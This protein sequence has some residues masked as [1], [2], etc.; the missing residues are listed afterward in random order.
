MTSLKLTD[1]MIQNQAHTAR[2]LQRL[3]SLAF[4]IKFFLLL[5]MFYGYQRYVP[6]HG[7]LI[8]TLMVEA[9]CLILLN[10]G[11]HQT[12]FRVLVSAILI[13]CLGTG[14]VF[15]AF[16]VY[17]MGGV[18]MA[19]I[20]AGMLLG[21][22]PLIITA[23]SGFGIWALFMTLNLSGIVPVTH[24]M[25]T[26]AELWVSQTGFV[27]LLLL[28]LCFM[29]RRLYHLIDI[30][31]AQANQLRATLAELQSTALSHS[32]I[33]KIKDE[34]EISNMRY[35]TVI[36]AST[37]GIIEWDAASG[38]IQIDETTAQL[39]G[40][41]TDRLSHQPQTLLQYVHHDD[42]DRV[43]QEYCQ[44]MQQG[45]ERYESECRIVRT[46]GRLAWVMMRGI[47]HYDD[48][49]RAQNMFIVHIDITERRE[50]EQ[51]LVEAKL[52]KEKLNLLAKFIN[53]ASHHFRT[54]LTVIMT[55]VWLLKRTQDEDKRRERIDFIEEHAITLNRLLE[56]MFKM[57][58]IDMVTAL[59]LEPTPVNALIEEVV[60]RSE[61]FARKN[62][63]TL[64]S[65]LDHT[66][67]RV[68][69]DPDELGQ[70]I[71]NV[72]EN[73]IIF[74]QPEGAVIITTRH[75]AH[76]VYIEVS[77]TGVGI[78]PEEQQRI[79]ERFYKTDPA[80]SKAGMG[81]GLTMSKKIIDL[82]GGEISVRSDE[83]RGSTF[84]IRLPAN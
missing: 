56:S 37:G 13:S 8:I 36:V 66:N 47:V 46:D 62:T 79:F 67:P 10:M 29:V 75:D 17:L 49:H 27:G 15:G 7:V 38:L 16:P 58:R 51:R 24:Q 41:E 3:L 1:L 35:Q 42:R 34:L 71:L 77:D 21:I 52:E 64:T 72:V 20:S 59:S 84:I 4:F 53:D 48:Q 31:N 5:F 78:P 2:L 23:I 73:G 28:M 32:Q 80:R 19:S 30:Q 61:N 45:K 69:A 12:A 83:G 82:H 57:F 25:L 18:L 74:N 50:A 65:V 70:A 33:S 60:E 26:T 54:S 14:L 55:S 44:L 81:L 11:H 63:V 6:Q 68:K 22:G 9:V 40:L 39:I 43:W 76:Y